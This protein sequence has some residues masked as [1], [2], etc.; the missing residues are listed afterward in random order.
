VYLRD[1]DFRLSSRRVAA[2]REAYLADEVVVTPSPR[3]HHLLADKRRLEIFSSG[4][5]LARLGVD[6]DDASF[7]AEVVPETRLLASM[8]A[9]EA[10]SSRRDWVFKP[11]A[12]FGSR[13]V[14]RGDKISHRKLDEIYR[15]EDFVAQRRIAPGEIEVATSDGP[16]R[17]KFDVRAYAYRDQVLMLGAR[18][19]QGQVTNFRSPGGGF[20]AIC[21][22]RDAAG[23]SPAED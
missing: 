21:V 10:W 17:M 13:A 18:A 1:T 12:A 9:D 20:S 3:E 23:A 2:L 11:A 14:Y 22:S 19:Y 15:G 16:Q 5:T 8:S 4:E 6:S 7:L